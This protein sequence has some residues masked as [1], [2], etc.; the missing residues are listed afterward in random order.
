M[1]SS[2]AFKK[3][4][5]V[6][7]FEGGVKSTKLSETFCQISFPEG[8]EVN[9]ALFFFFKYALWRMEMFCLKRHPSRFI[10]HFLVADWTAVLHIS[11]IIFIIHLEKGS[12]APLTTRQTLF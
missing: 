12:A 8:T 4:R 11:S 9:L 2:V 1:H 3:T 6:L 5:A 7:I 10:I